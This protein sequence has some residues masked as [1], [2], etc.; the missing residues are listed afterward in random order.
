MTSEVP[1][2]PEAPC[3][4]AGQGSIQAKIRPGVWIPCIRSLHMYEEQWKVSANPV[5][6]SK[7]V[8]QAIS[9]LRT[10]SLRGN[11]FTVAYVEEKT[12]RSKLEILV[13]SR[14]RYVFVIKLD[15]V[16]E[17]FAG[18]TARV[19]AFSSGAFPSWFPLSFLFSSLFFFVP[20]Y[21]LGKNALWI[22]ILR[23]QMTIPIEITEKGRKC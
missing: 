8:L 17:E 18:C 9:K 23:S 21:D 19:R 14:M 16:N 2:A 12:E 15:F 20:F 10:R 1:E 13:F 7:D 4:C 3:L 6:C 5:V 22:N 11:V